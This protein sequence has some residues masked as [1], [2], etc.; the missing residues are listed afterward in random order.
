MDPE[1]LW[2]LKIKTTYKVH[3]ELIS[4]LI[5]NTSEALFLWNPHPWMRDTWFIF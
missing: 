5:L 3:V 2:E 4:V 1:M